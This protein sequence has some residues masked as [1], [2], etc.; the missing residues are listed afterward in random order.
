M[1]AFSCK[2]RVVKETELV[3]D[4]KQDKPFTRKRFLKQDNYKLEY[5]YDW[6]IDTAAEDFDINSN[7]SIESPDDAY[8]L[9]FIFNASI[10]EK[11]HIREQVKAHL[12]KTIKGGEVRYFTNW[13]K[14]R[15]YGA[16]INGKI[17]GAFKSRLM[18]FAHSDKEASFMAF[19]QLSEPHTS[20]DSIGLD[21]IEKSFRLVE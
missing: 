15:G 3:P 2:E 5:L 12:Q 9:F 17:M 14:Y 20:R 21:L 11:E 8:A 10:D 6:K 7:F 18:I 1:A 19:T 13:G 16:V 4:Q